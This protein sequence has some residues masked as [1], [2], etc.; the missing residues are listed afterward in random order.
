VG[1]VCDTEVIDDATQLLVPAGASYQ[2]SDVRC[3]L[4]DVRIYG[5]LRV[6]PLDPGAPVFTG[7]LGLLATN[8]TLFAGATL[9]ADGAGQP[10]G[11]PSAGTNI[12]G[13]QGAGSSPGCGGGPGSSV[14][15]GGNGA[16]YGGAGGVPTNTYVQNN[17]CTACNEPPD[18]VH[19]A[20]AASQPTGTATGDDFD[21][22]SGG[23]AGGNSS[24]CSSSG[25]RG[26]HGGGMVLLLASST[27]TID[28]L[29]TASGETPP[30]DPSACGYHPGGGG[31]SGGSVVLSAPTVVG[32]GTVYALGGNGGQA[33]GDASSTWGWGG[34]GGGGGRVKVFAPDNQ[35]GGLIRVDGGA[36]GASPPDASSAPGSPGDA[37]SV[38]IDT[39][40]PA[41]LVYGG[42]CP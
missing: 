9:V 37:G 35:F 39:T 34:G 36:G 8:I 2:T 6:T 30:P 17:L 4:G 21:M 24:G 28:G 38:G 40:I 3:F 13:Q 20:S 22:G 41:S 27:I 16:A 12:G 18:P 5:E 7:A 23:G 33:L 14:G 31:G 15:Q 32:L 11:L 1:D 25:G 29:V 42:T 19:C 26:G 10:G